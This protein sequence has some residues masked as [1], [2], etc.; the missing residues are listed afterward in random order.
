MAAKSPKVT[1]D[2]LMPR[3]TRFVSSGGDCESFIIKKPRVQVA[4]EFGLEETHN[5]LIRE[6]DLHAVVAD[7]PKLLEP[8]NE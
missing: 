8:R 7:V 2:S 5:V 4:S 3:K 6:F 1:S